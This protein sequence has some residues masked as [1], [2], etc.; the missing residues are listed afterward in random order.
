T[1][2]GMMEWEIEAELL[3]EFRRHG[4]QAAY[5]SIVGGGANGCILHYVDNNAA[6][7][8][9]ELLLVDAGCEYQGYASD[10]SRTWPINGRFTSE[11]RALYEIVLEAQLQAIDKVRAGG[12]WNA[13]H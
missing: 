1:R 13:P 11:Q 3:H 12:H 9:G 2:P 4:G 8:S 7:N 10:I 5:P 6:L